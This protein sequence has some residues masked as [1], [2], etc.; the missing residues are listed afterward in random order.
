[1]NKIIV[2]LIGSGLMF[3]LATFAQAVAIN[4]EWDLNPTSGDWNTSANWTPMIVPNGPSDT[5]TF[6]LSNRTGVSISRNTEV[7]GI[8]FTS[9]AA[10]ANN[11]FDE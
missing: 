2:S 1:M 6:A 11:S 4:A 8:T 3:L 9:A 10:S 5:A 7:N